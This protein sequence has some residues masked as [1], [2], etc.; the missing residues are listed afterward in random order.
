[1]TQD[2]AIDV[3]DQL[4]QDHVEVR[5]LFTAFET[6]RTA[7]ERSDVFR[8]IVHDLDGQDWR[9]VLGVPV[10]LGGHIGGGV[11]GTH[12]VVAANFA[13]F[14]DQSIEDRLQVGGHNVA[15]D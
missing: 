2:Q 11:G 15:V 1:M 6:A 3:V 9:L 10:F 8:H 5:S 14:G 4:L 12:D 7:E 13:A